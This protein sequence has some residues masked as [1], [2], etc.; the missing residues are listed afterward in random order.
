M[1]MLFSCAPENKEYK[2]VM[3]NPTWLH[4]VMQHYTDIIVHDIF[5]PPVASRNYAYTTIAGYEAARHLDSSFLSLEGQ[6]N[7]LTNVPKPDPSKTYCFELSAIRAMLTTGKK[8]IFSEQDYIAFEQK[9]MAEIQTIH[10]PKEVHDNSLAYGDQVAKHIMT[11]ADGDN[12][13]Q[14]RSFSKFSINTQDKT[15]WRPTPPAYMDAIEPHWNSIRPL[16]MDSAQQF[17]P[18]PGTPFDTKKGSPFMKD[19][20][21]VYEVGKNLTKEQKAIADFWDCNPYKLNVTGHVM[22]ATKKITPGGHWMSI[23][24]LT[25]LKAK[26]DFVTTTQTYALT[27]LA[28]FDGFISCWD[29]KFRSNL[30]RPESI[31]NDYIDDTW[32]PMIQTPPF[33]EYT[34]G[35]S[36]ISAAS[37]EVLTSLY[38]DNFA[39]ADSTELRFGL[40]VRKFNSFYEAANEAA[41][42]RLYG[43]IHYRPAIYNGVAQ[44]KQIGKYIM[45]KVK[46]K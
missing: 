39:F 8:F 34:S 44:G 29:E 3:S 40:P 13:K 15:R 25:A 10:I 18:I 46:F 43:G 17:K 26:S 11:W 2:V 22:H 23:S 12:Y 31:I 33:P 24:R 14:S 9:L 16:V 6:L 35:H 30:I 21:E 36:V 41:I 1:V 32:L 28:L 45:E 38:G 27:S 5:S 7:G 4:R 42:S 19:A 37:A 20:M